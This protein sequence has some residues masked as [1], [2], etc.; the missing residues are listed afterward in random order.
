[1]RGEAGEHHR[2]GRP[3]PPLP[4]TRCA[5]SLA[6]GPLSFQGQ[7]PAGHRRP[8]QQLPSGRAPRYPQP[9]DVAPDEPSVPRHTTMADGIVG[10]ATLLPPSR[11]GPSALAYDA[12]PLGRRW[13]TGCSQSRRAEP[14]WVSISQPT[15]A[16]ECALAPG[17][18]TGTAAVKPSLRSVTFCATTGPDRPQLGPS[19]R[20]HP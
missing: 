16:P 13:R 7:L 14:S 3:R 2:A 9:G 19:A 17:Q 4:V 11:R 6:V 8:A 20:P 15:R 10:R 5:A 12:I 18:V 1:M